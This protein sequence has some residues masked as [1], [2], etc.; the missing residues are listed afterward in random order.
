MHLPD[1]CVRDMSNT[2]G[3]GQGNRQRKQRPIVLQ[4]PRLVAMTS[5]QEQEAVSLL[6]Q[7]LLQ[8]W[9][10]QRREAR[11]GTSDTS[12]GAAAGQTDAENRTR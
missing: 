2:Q 1:Y 8:S 11:G 5:E 12:S 6:S 3:S 9:E 10:R 7:L 4:P